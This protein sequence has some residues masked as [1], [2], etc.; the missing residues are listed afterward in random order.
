MTERLR[1]T[2]RRPW[3]T[4]GLGVGSATDRREHHDADGDRR[5]QTTTTSTGSSAPGRYP[6]T[7]EEDQV[8]DER[9]T[10][11]SS[12]SSSSSS[13]HPGDR[14]ERVPRS[15]SSPAPPRRLRADPEDDGAH[16]R[17]RGSTARH[18]V[19]RDAASTRSMMDQENHC[20]G[21]LSTANRIRSIAS[22][23]HLRTCPRKRRS[24]PS[25]HRAAPS[26]GSRGAGRRAGSPTPR[27]TTPAVAPEHPRGLGGRAERDVLGGWRDGDR[28]PEY[29]GGDAPRRIQAGAAADQQ[30]PPGFARPPGRSP[31][32]RRRARTACPRSP[33]ARVRAS[34]SRGSAPRGRSR[35]G[36]VWRALAREVRHQHDAAGAGL[37]R[38]SERPEPSWSTPS[39]AAVTSTTCAAFNVATSGR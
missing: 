29:L 38:K 6:A 15:R 5:Y 33:P 20:P 13:R 21:G 36:Q 4:R 8:L 35:V 39:R 30:Q 18:N 37:R 22:A 28:Q 1:P 17:R 34:S 27:S 10:S 14:Q 2:R 23:G 7:P 3:D 12:S 16:A 26:R 31:R 32:A 9:P 24:D 25:H 19:L 11:S